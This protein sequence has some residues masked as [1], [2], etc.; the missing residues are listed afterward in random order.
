MHHE[1]LLRQLWQLQADE[2]LS[3][4]ALAREIGVSQSYLSRLQ[5]GQR[6]KR[7]GLAFQRKVVS[8][9]PS[10]GLLLPDDLRIGRVSITD[11]RE[12]A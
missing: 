6:G 4:N 5:T 7:P 10:L 2:G 9:F 1:T 3:T 12:G 8:R 11:G